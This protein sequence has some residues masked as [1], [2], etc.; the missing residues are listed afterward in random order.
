MVICKISTLGAWPGLSLHVDVHMK[1]YNSCILIFTYYHSY[2]YVMS[3]YGVCY[4]YVNISILHY[5]FAIL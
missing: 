4:V 1:S 5:G 3:S 2:V